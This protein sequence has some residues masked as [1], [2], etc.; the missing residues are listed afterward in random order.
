METYTPEFEAWWK[1]NALGRLRGVARLTD[2]QL[3]T[4]KTV[5]WDTWK[6]GREKLYEELSHQRVQPQKAA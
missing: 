5:C 6:L 4:A 1:A 2:A 3:E